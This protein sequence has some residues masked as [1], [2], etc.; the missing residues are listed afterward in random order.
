M[1]GVSLG[2]AWDTGDTMTEPAQHY[3]SATPRGELIAKPITVTL[4]GKPRT[5]QTAGSVFSPDHLDRG[6]EMLL[7][8]TPLASRGPI[9]DLGCGWGAIALE[10]ALDAPEAEVW[11]I[12]VNERARH[13]TEANAH[14]LGL[15][16]IR[17]TDPTRVPADLR[18]HEIRSNPPIRIGKQALHELLETWLPRLDD[19]GTAYL[20]VAKHLGAESLQRWITDTFPFLTVD[21]LAREK[22]F[23]II[24]AARH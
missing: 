18:F 11:A 17:V 4:A 6:T 5:V 12:D 8:H 19:G 23:H 20:V 15:T 9:L 10:A 24:R 16:N 14:A 1:Y 22:G 2:H 13:L 21:R 7:K 3:F